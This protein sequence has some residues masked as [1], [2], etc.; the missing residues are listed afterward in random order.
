MELVLILMLNPPVPA[1]VTG[2]RA[3]VVN[4][5]FVAL[6]RA[7]E[8]EDNEHGN[9]FCGHCLSGLVYRACGVKGG[10]FFIAL[11]KTLVCVVQNA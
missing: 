4:E 3:M 10:A 1:L 2:L 8:V 5:R 7:R 11:A 9:R 6:V